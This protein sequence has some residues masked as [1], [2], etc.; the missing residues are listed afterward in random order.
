[1]V[2]ADNQWEAAAYYFD[3][4]PSANYELQVDMNCRGY[5]SIEI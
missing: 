1:M 4:E 5:D 3:T 2:T